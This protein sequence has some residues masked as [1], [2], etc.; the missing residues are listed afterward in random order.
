MTTKSDK[1]LAFLY[2]LYIAPD[3]GERFAELVDEHVQLPKQGRALYVEAGTGGHALVLQERGGQKFTIVCADQNEE[4][5]ELARAKAAA[6]HQSTTFQRENPQ[7]FLFAD[8]EFDL[9]LGNLSFTSPGNVRQAVNELV[10]VTKTGGT[11]ACWLPTA[12]SFGEFFSIYWE[13]LLGAGVEDHGAD[14]ERLIAELPTVTDVEAWAEEAGLEEVQ[15]WTA[16]EEF[17]FESG[18]AFLNSP[19]IQDFLLPSWLHSIPEAA[20]EKVRSEL[21]RIIDEER[22]TAEFALSL[23]ATLVVGKKARV[24]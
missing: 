22:H 15:P 4:C 11:T 7:A 10:R 19:L 18:E 2:D 24:Q 8:D 14:V 1:E 9:V 6:L 21:A 12:G 16:I 3:W 23:K 20:R 5:L 13:A 17:D